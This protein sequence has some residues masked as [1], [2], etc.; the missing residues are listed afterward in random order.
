MECNNVLCKGKF[1]VSNAY[2]GEEERLNYLRLTL[3]K[4]NRKSYCKS[5]VHGSK[6]TI[7]SRGETDE[8]H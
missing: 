1:M 8:T 6:P 4:K 2:T 5:K 7:K 3:K